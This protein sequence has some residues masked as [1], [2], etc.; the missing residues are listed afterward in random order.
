MYCGANTLQIIKCCRSNDALNVVPQSGIGGD[1]A[2]SYT[3][4][5]GAMICISRSKSVGAT[6]VAKDYQQGKVGKIL[7]R[8]TNADFRMPE[9]V[10]WCPLAKNASCTK[11]RMQGNM[12][13]YIIDRRCKRASAPAGSR[14]SRIAQHQQV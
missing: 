7:L 10:A 13:I 5:S 3:I 6:S 14:S 1:E 9:K 8:S 2:V 12:R 11:A 4:V